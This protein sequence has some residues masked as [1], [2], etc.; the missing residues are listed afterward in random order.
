MLEVLGEKVPPWPTEAFSRAY[1]SYGLTG[2]YAAPQL[3]S[4]REKINSRGI[5]WL[6]ICEHPVLIRLLILGSSLVLELSLSIKL[7]T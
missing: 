7:S 3:V 6:P 5:K 4:G 1:C 2:S